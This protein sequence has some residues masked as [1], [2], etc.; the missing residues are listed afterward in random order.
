M[1]SRGGF[2]FHSGGKS[3]PNV[4]PDL[5]EDGLFPHQGKARIKDVENKLGKLSFILDSNC[6]RSRLF[7]IDAI[8]ALVQRLV[9]ANRHRSQDLAIRRKRHKRETR[10]TREVT[11]LLIGSNSIGDSA[12]TT[13]F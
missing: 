3:Q 1:A 12:C 11:I 10:L 2:P 7:L 9:D 8:Q 5:G 6:I 13:A 4:S